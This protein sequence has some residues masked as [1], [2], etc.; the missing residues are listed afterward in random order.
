[1]RHDVHFADHAAL[2][3]A[4][5]LIEKF[6]DHAPSEAARLAG[7]SREVG[8]VI[9]FCRWRQIERMIDMLR[10]EAVTGAVH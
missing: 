4:A 10:D 6:G 2:A 7:E 1:M 8:N 5:S 9:H 3:E